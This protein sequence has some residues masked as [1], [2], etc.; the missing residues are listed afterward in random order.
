MKNTLAKIAFEKNELEEICEL[1]VGPSMLFYGEDDI[2]PAAKAIAKF[3][4]KFPGLVVKTI[5]FDNTIFPKEEFATFISMPTKDEVRAQFL[6]VLMAPQTQFVGV[7]N[8]ASRVVGVLRSYAD[9]K[10][11]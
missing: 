6:S 9:K 3:T 5:I 8:A 4:R 10:A 2:A 1:L 7:I 11:E